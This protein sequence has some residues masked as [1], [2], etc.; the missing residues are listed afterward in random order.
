MKPSCHKSFL[1]IVAVLFCSAITAV[2]TLAVNTINFSPTAPG[3]DKSVP[4]WGVDTA[5]PNFDNV[6]QSIHHIGPSNVEIARVLVYFDEPLVNLGGGN[7]ELNAAAKAKVDNHLNLVAQL[8]SNVPITFGT[9][10]T[11]LGEIDSS[12]L[13]GGGVNVTQYANAI[14]ATQAYINSQ[15]GFTGSP[16]Y[17][18]EPFNEPD[19]NVPYANP[20]D[21]NSIIGQ[22]KTHPAFSSTLMMAPSVLNSDFRP[23]LVRSGSSSDRRFVA[24]AGRL[25][26]QLHELYQPRE[27]R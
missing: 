23:R 10:G 15:A 21:L 1:L 20:I 4:V 25:A 24:S 3:I 18:I 5:W 13:Q 27:Q 22:L 14:K 11:F 8:G 7:Y 17:A 26:D 2:P 16:I 9:G 12:Y 6:R 19:F